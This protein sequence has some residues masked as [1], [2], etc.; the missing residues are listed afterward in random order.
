MKTTITPKA[1]DLTI[2]APISAEYTAILTPEALQFVVA[3][4]TQVQ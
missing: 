2:E 1:L 3:L 4:H